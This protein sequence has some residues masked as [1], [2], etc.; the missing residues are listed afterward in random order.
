MDEASEFKASSRHDLDRLQAFVESACE[1]AGADAASYFALR[2][3]VEESF[4]NIMRYAYGPDGG[5]VTV[6]VRNDGRRITIVMRDE[7]PPF[8]PTRVP[9]PDLSADWQHREAGGLG[10]HLL[11]NMMDDVAYAR[12]ADGG[13]V[14][15]MAK[16]ISRAAAGP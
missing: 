1:R 11:M 14:L 5:P 2:L 3:A 8:D 7:G 16:E 9:A 4:I 13:N 6:N 15:T 10:V 12:D